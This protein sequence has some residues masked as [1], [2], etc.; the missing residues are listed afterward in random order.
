MTRRL[1]NAT[2]SFDFVK[3]KALYCIQSFPIRAK[4]GGQVVFHSV[5]QMEPEALDFL[6]FLF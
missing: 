4:A 2:G 5:L 6:K 3:I 1:L